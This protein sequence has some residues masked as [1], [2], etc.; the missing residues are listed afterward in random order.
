MKV[1]FLGYA[2]DSRA[3]RVFNKTSQIIMESVNVT[4][5]ESQHPQA[6][7]RLIPPP[8]HEVVNVQKENEVVTGIESD[9][10][11]DESS[12]KVQPSTQK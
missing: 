7:G 8:D 9:S 1:F 2:T 3:Y 12:V 4:F 10:D 5:D 6:P 11:E